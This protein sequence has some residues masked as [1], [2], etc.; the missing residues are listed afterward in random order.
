[1]P[2]SALPIVQVPAAAGRGHLGSASREQRAAW[3]TVIVS[4][5][6]MAADRPSIQLGLLSSILKAHHFP[7]RTLHANLDFAHLIGADR[8]NRLCEQRGPMVAEWLFS[9]A[10]FGDAAPD[11]DSRLLDDLADQLGYLAEQSPGWREELL[12]IRHHDVPNYLDALLSSFDWSSVRVVGF[13]STHQQNTASFALARRLKESFPDIV[14]LFGGANF[15]GEMGPELVRSVDCIDLAVTGEA[16]SALPELMCALAAGTDPVVVPGVIGRVD[17]TVVATPPRAPL[18]RLDDLP[19]P[20]YSEYFQRAEDL[21]LLERVGHRE[22]RIPFESARG[23]W[24]GAKHHCTFCGLNGLTMEFRSKSPR[25]VLDELAEQAR[26][27]R[28]FRFEAV[29][30]ILDMR[31]V[32]ELFPQLVASEADYQI[33]YEVK[34]NLTRAQLRLLAQGGVTSIQPGLESMSSHVLRLMRKGVRAAQNVNLLRWAAYYKI[35]VGWNVLWGFPGETLEDYAQQAA[36]F[37]H[38]VHLRPPASAGRVWLERFSPL[39]TDSEAFGVRERTPEASYGYIYPD[40]VDLPRIAYF[41]DYTLSDAL[42]DSAYDDLQQAVHRWQEAWKGDHRPVLKYWASP[43]FVQI[44]D[45]RHQGSEGT[46]TFEGDLAEIYLACSE[47]P[48]SA[49]AVREKLGR[50]LPVEAVLEAFA[51]FHRRGLLFLD[52]SIAIALAIPAGTMR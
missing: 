14:T 44:Y 19:T 35:D 10:A 21:G 38:L 7:V 26:R 18:D 25:R 5:P 52:E 27:Y 13:T 24:W 36:A 12:K 20:D 37:G 9:L 40:S 29:D 30:N 50:R 11:R 46:Y 34:S 48:V 17:G 47:R 28:S 16:D 49:A 23:C 41:F 32:T 43:G 22:V 42:P 31:Y 39:Y 1:M 15:D 33:F 6:F 2:G 51:E 4:M 45:G 3:P 8:Y